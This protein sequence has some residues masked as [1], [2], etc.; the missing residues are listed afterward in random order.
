[1][2]IL[3][4]PFTLFAKEIKVE[5]ELK[6]VDGEL[7][8]NVRA[9][10]SVEQ[11]KNHP[12][13]TSRRIRRL[14]DQATSEIERALQPFGY[15]RP[16]ISS[17][18]IVPEA[19]S[20]IWS[21][22]YVIEPG[23]PLRLTDVNFVMIGAG[24]DD[25]AM[26]DE[27]ANFPLKTGD[28]LAHALYE[29]GK[30]RLEGLAEERGYFQA[31]F[32][33]HKILI[34]R[35]IYNAR[36]ELTLDTGPRFCLGKIKFIQNNYQFDESFLKTFIPFELGDSYT[37]EA[38]LKL[39]SRL[40][41]SN[42]FEKIDLQTR[43]VSSTQ[44][45]CVEI[46]VILDARRRTFVQ[47][48]VGYGTDT[49]VRARVSG[50]YRRLNRYGHSLI[51]EV[52]V[53]QND[54]KYVAKL[55][56]IIPIGHIH[57]D[58]W[59]MTLRYQ[60]EDQD[61]DDLG[62]GDDFELEGGSTRVE[63]LSFAVS[64]NQRRNLLGFEVDEELS[65]T[66]LLESFD[67]I[68][69]LFADATTQELLRNIFQDELDILSPDYKVFMP[70]ITWLY[71]RADN[72]VYIT[73]GE[74]FSLSLRGSHKDVLS[75]LSF[76]QADAKATLIRPLGEKSRVIVK[77]QV[78]YTQADEKSFLDIT[79]A[80]LPKAIQY[81]TGGDRTVRGYAFERLNGDNTL[82]EGRHIMLGSIEYEYRFLNDWSAA[83][84]VDSGNVTNDFSDFSIKTSAGLGIR[85]H[86]P[87]GLVKLDFAKA[88]DDDDADPWRFHLTIGP[89]F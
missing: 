31:N 35:S 62:I 18:L 66:Y 28:I 17:E 21:A 60:G 75:N 8:T 44:G 30:R 76:F 22:R 29:E 34:D 53:T 88:L 24:N 51:G 69:L 61:G 13:M 9:Y 78:G 23:E 40:A 65:L 82:I 43:R 77:G 37:A 81:A 87:I 46:D 89:E 79:G 38:V 86:S 71:R 47:T 41:E 1:M 83:T 42:L 6:G 11:Q 19:D 7:L 4:T 57:T 48:R 64:R 74:M 45:A 54:Q 80:V 12:Q 36:I 33:E 72:F 14:H 10:L 20:N 55:D 32:V 59:A 5:V 2:V 50:G 70:G 56:Y 16:E 68:E 63:S 58:F 39:H 84:F 25:Q 67:L 85:W 49:G 15:Y 52:G 27:V 3:L 26:L 73:H